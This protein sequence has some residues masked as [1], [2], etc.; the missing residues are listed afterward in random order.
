MNEAKCSYIFSIAYTVVVLFVYLSTMI[1]SAFVFQK[2]ISLSQYPSRACSSP[3]SSISTSGTGFRGTYLSRNI[4][5]LQSVQQLEDCLVHHEVD[6]QRLQS[7]PLSRV[8]PVLACRASGQSEPSFQIVLT[9]KRIDV[10]AL[11]SPTLHLPCDLLTSEQNWRWFNASTE[12]AA[13]GLALFL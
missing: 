3:C 10:V 11:F 13:R 5:D 2:S 8:G 9:T 6:V 7:P 4:D 1:T 12:V